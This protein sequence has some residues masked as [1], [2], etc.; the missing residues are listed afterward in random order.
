MTI[1]CSFSLTSSSDQIGLTSA[2]KKQE[3]KSMDRL[4]GKFSGPLF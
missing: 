4:Y 3:V 1:V 2:S